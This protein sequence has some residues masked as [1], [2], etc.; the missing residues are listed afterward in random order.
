VPASTA[1]PGRRARALAFRRVVA[2][3]G[4]RSAASGVVLAVLVTWSATI[5]HPVSA[6]LVTLGAL[7]AAV[8]MA[9]DTPGV[10]RRTSIA[11]AFGAL[12][13]FVAVSVALWGRWTLDVSTGL[14][15]LGL[16]MLVDF[17]RGARDVWVLR[18]TRWAVR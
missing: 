10:G 5:V 16:F 6:P 13:V 2:R 8:V 4:A 15:A 11:L 12:A 7:L 3:R 9:A 17:A 14:G 18:V 1:P